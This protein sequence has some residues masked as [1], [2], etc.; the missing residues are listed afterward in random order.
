MFNDVV[1]YDQEQDIVDYDSPRAVSQDQMIPNSRLIET[2]REYQTP[3][4]SQSTTQ[5]VRPQTADTYNREFV[6]PPEI[7]ANKVLTEA[8]ERGYPNF[9]TYRPLVDP[10]SGIAPG[11]VQTFL[12]NATPEEKANFIKA[13]N[14]D[15]DFGVLEGKAGQKLEEEPGLSTGQEFEYMLAPLGKIFAPG[16]KEAWQLRGLPPSVKRAARLGDRSELGRAF[17]R[18][19]GA[20]G[21]KVD[22]KVLQRMSQVLENKPELQSL[23]QA[24]KFS[25]DE[26]EAIAQLDALHEFLQTSRLSQELGVG[27]LPLKEPS[28]GETLTARDISSNTFEQ[29]RAYD[30][31]RQIGENAVP[32]V[33]NITS[34][35]VPLERT[36]KVVANTLKNRYKELMDPAQVLYKKA[37]TGAGTEPNIDVSD[38]VEGL[39]QQLM[40]MGVQPEEVS[41]IIK[42]L[43]P[44]GRS[45]TQTQEDALKVLNKTNAKIK[46]LEAKGDLS[47]Q[48]ID[49]LTNLYDT[50]DQLASLT[51]VKENMISE[52]DLLNAVPKLGALLNTSNRAFANT[53]KANTA[54]AQARQYLFKEGETLL[55]KYGGADRLKLLQQANKKAAPAYNMRDATREGSNIIGSKLGELNDIDNMAELSSL[56]DDP[57]KMQKLIS[58]VGRPELRKGLGQALTNQ[59]VRQLVGPVNELDPLRLNAVDFNK[60]STKLNTV[61]NDAETREFLKRNMSAERF[62]DLQALQKIS[63]AMGPLLKDFKSNPAASNMLEYIKGGEGL[64][65]KLGNTIET[66]YDFVGYLKNKVINDIPVTNLVT[67]PISKIP[68]LRWTNSRVDVAT[69]RIERLQNILEG[70]LNAIKEGKLKPEEIADSLSQQEEDALNEMADMF[71]NWSKVLGKSAEAQINKAIKGE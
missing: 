51:E 43:E 13:I 30:K 5:V 31:M 56:L 11:S 47:Q 49:T 68:G 71:G 7:K 67:K 66:I 28:R 39:R 20:S 10:M 1:D 50:R 21:D 15:R 23:L 69:G 19:V 45:L 6:V 25:K 61:F 57:I 17:Y 54:L 14:F 48:E 64:K 4:V 29:R 38:F 36:T 60:L 44:R 59:K 46:S 42:T 65:S 26:K 12:E 70:K 35:D 52:L 40:D 55:E 2:P 62:A 33:K 32:I 34:A 9:E 41:A 24:G 37:R 27:D 8:Y 16:I 3:Q 63:N 58:S 53:D 18:L 22:P